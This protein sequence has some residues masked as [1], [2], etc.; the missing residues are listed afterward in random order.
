MSNIFLLAFCDRSYI[1]EILLIVKTFFKLACYLAPFLVMA[2]SGVHLFKVV[3]NGKKDDLKDALKV[4]VKRLIAG[5]IIFFI[6]GLINYVFTGIVNASEVEFLACFESASRARVETLKAREKAAA[7]AE[8]KTQEKEDEKILRKAWEEEQKQQESK[9]QSFEEWKKSR[10]SKGAGAGAA[11]SVS[12]KTD[13]DNRTLNVTKAIDTNVNNPDSGLGDGRNRYRAVQNA[14]YTGNHVVYAQNKNYG[15]IESSSKGGRICWSE[16]STGKQTKCVEVSAEGGHMDGLAYDNDRGYVLKTVS[17]GRLLQLDN[18]TMEPAGYAKISETHVGI[19]YVPSVHS[20]VGEEDG[21][22]IFYKY[23]ASTNTYERDYTVQ[24]QG[25]DANAVQG[26]GTDG[27]NIFIADSSPWDSKK[28]LYTYSLDGRKLEV[29][30]F[31]SGFGGMSDEVES[32]FA[33]NDGNLYLACPQGIAKVTNY[34][35]NKIGLPT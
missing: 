29:H 2:I 25:F 23:N 18:K 19:T 4:T 27:T 17:G 5:F 21:K 8:K 24:L 34:R 12:D 32:A 16:I 33:D 11:H 13:Y 10:G 15:S 20:L 35:A 9:K 7:E 30:S 14:A 1:V 6:P 28:N 22:L 26:I 3:M 31:G